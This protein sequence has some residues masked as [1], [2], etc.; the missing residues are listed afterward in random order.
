MDKVV[1]RRVL[2]AVDA[3]TACL[4]EASRHDGT[5]I[6]SHHV[7][8]QEGTES[9][10][11]SDILYEKMRLITGHGLWLLI[12]GDG[13]NNSEHGI[14]R[15]TCDAL[16]FRDTKPF[17]MNHDT[18]SPSGRLHGFATP[19]RFDNMVRR[20]QR[21]AAGPVMQG[22]CTDK[23]LENILVIAGRVECKLIR[24]VHEASIDCILASELG[25]EIRSLLDDLNMNYIDI[26]HGSM[27]IFGMSMLKTLLALNNPTITFTLFEQ[28]NHSDGKN[29]IDPSPLEPVQ[30][31]RSK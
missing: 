13:L 5:L 12:L 14:A 30:Q 16:G 28:G 20:V 17:C 18:R 21:I 23:I 19:E 2:V 24:Q 6:I 1:M 31:T 22:G 15:A 25:H 7:L 10:V 8:F 29:S 9:R 4:D 27:D 3:S 26:L 11:P